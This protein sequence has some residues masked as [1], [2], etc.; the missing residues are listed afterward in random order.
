MSYLSRRDFMR[1]AS[2]AAALP[3][4]SS[5]EL[6]AQNL[7]GAPAVS[8][9]LPM[10]ERSPKAQELLAYPEAGQSLQLNPPGFTW[11]PHNDARSYLL[12]IRAAREGSTA[13]QSTRPVLTSTL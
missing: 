12:E 4:F 3:S 7:A 11:T 8:A 1:R 10:L 13:L 9:S 2:L 5:L 6:V